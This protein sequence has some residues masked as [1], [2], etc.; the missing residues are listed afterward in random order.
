M[1]A[2]PISRFNWCHYVVAAT[3]ILTGLGIGPIAGAQDVFPDKAL[4]KA[5][6]W[7]VF[8]KRYNDQ[9]ITA[10]DVK[11][12]SQVVARG[13]GI[14]S[15]AGLEHC[16]AIMKIDLAN[17]EITDLTSI[18]E[19]KNVQ[20][21]D[22]SGNQIASIEH[23]ANLKQM[24][25]LQ[26]SKNQISDLAPIAG[27]QKLNSLYLNDNKITNLTAIEGLRKLWTLQLAGNPIESIPSLSGLKQLKTLN[28]RN[29][30]ISKVDFLAD[31]K[32]LNL[33][34]LDQN[35]LESLVTLV[36]S[37]EADTS[38]QYAPF[39]KLYLDAEQLKKLSPEIDRLKASNVKI[40]PESN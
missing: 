10:D 33:L 39:L 24:Q 35:P 26:L 13:K 32:E 8:E 3:A 36:E 5:I 34:M 25:Y 6:R 23:L 19:L 40:N 17:N 29:C 15:L 22:L 38:K 20:S 12:I 30:K 2:N 7:E 27:M 1:I 14:K 31:L 16:K 9:P 4:E 11:N 18:A 37:C 21:L 28:L